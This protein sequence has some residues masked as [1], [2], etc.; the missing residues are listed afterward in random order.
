MAV[1][2]GAS[3]WRVVAASSFPFL[4]IL[5][6][7]LFGAFG[8]ESPFFPAL[9]STRGLSS[10]EIGTAL[11]AGTLVRLSCGP[12]I[13]IAA[14]LYGIRRV[15]ALTAV[16]TGAIMLLYLWGRGFW[17]L[18]TIGM[19]HSIVIAP[20]N[21][22]A[23]S[24]SLTATRDG[25]FPYG[26]IRGVGSAGFICG[27]MISGLL[28]TR[29]GIDSIVVA[30]AI[31]FT[32]MIVP[33]PWLAPSLTASAEIARGGVPALLAVP[34]FR[35]MLLVAGLIMGSHAMSDTFAVI[36]W[37]A[38]GTGATA[39]GLLWS[40]A[41]ASEILVFV[42]LGPWLLRRLGPGPCVAIAAL[43]GVLRWSVLALTADLA[44]LIAAQALHGLTFSLMHLACMQIIAAVV[45]EKL[46]A[47]AQTLYGTLSVGIA[48]AAMTLLSGQLYGAFGKPAFW[49]MSAL[50]AL[51][52]PLV[53]GLDPR[54]I[55]AKPA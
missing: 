11:A 40:E 39:I 44:P 51:A 28:V 27:T 1:V 47:T 18:L 20:L 34:V 38:A 12:M 2:P 36:Q 4:A 19:I 17:P 37:R 3:G 22:L 50:C 49:M 31:L 24:L 13:G 6:L 52:L 9:L 15:L 30:A 26:W 21:P 32:M 41:V 25:V 35:R 54:G 55:E 42:V 53:R 23:D 29:F 48:T 14:D 5:Y 7:A 16:A 8:I 46:S 10:A 43:A 33:L 45:P